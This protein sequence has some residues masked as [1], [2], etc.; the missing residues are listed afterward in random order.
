[1]IDKIN[2]ILQKL[3]LFWRPFLYYKIAGFWNYWEIQNF[4]KKFQESSDFGS[5]I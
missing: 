3:I 4:E 2:L 5:N 1:M